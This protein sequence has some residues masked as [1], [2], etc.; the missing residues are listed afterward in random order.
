M[1]LMRNT[2]ALLRGDV[3]H[4]AQLVASPGAAWALQSGVVLLVASGVYGLTVGLWR[5]PIQSLFTGIKIPLLILLT[6]A[7]N[8]LL[9]GMLAQLLGSGLAMRQTTIA[10]LSSFA[11][12]SVVLAAL[13]PIALFIVL[14]TPPLDATNAVTV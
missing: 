8:A 3:E 7:G 13:S 10:I 11:A 2:G 14:N 6:C 1:K 12:A 5:S 9:N 4:I